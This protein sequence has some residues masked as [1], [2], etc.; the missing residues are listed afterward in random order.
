VNRRHFLKATA[1]VAAAIAA[2]RTFAAMPR[3]PRILLRSS[4]Q[5]VN[6]GDIGHTPGVLALLE[7]YIPE[8]QVRLWP[9]NVGNGVE[10]MLLRRFPQLTIVRPAEVKAAFDEC[11]FLL[12]GSGAS[13]VAAN[14][15]ENWRQQTGKPFGIYGIT[16]SPAAPARDIELISKARFAFFRDSVSLKVAQEK[17]AACPVMEFGPDGAFAVDVRNDEAAISPSCSISPAQARWKPSPPC[18]VLPSN[19]G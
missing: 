8:A 4:W 10:Q 13:L 5:T 19:A 9:S 2:R 7:K 6:I 11:D 3:K 1:G 16:F 15:V 18:A 14:D 12:H 17:G